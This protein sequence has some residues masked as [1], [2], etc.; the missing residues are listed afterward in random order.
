MVAGGKC[1]F[2]FLAAYA[3][4]YFRTGYGTFIFA[5]IMATLLLP[6]DLRVVTTYQVV[7]NI[8]LPV[9]ILLEYSG[10]NWLIELLL[11]TR[12]YFEVNLLNTYVGFA[13]PLVAHGT[14]TFLFRQFFRTL[15]AD[16]VRA[17][18]M[19]GAGPIRFLF[20]ILLPLAKA[21]LVALFILMFL[22]GW[23]QYLWPLVASS[24]PETYTAVIGLAR[25]VP[26]DDAAIPKYPVIMAGALVVSAI[27]PL[28]IAFLQRYIVRGLSLSEHS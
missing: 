13:A 19:D 7:A 3:I 14:G 10:I 9:N 22:G 17:S 26:T 27:P 12:L 21:Y 20:D 25:L 4:V 2:A 1:V 8:M 23:T 5:F 6:V 16:L 28:L 24:G 11:G 18:A 15:P